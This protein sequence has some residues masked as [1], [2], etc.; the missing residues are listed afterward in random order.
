M[1]L[2]FRKAV[3][4]TREKVSSVSVNPIENMLSTHSLMIGEFGMFKAFWYSSLYVVIEG[5]VDLKLSIPA[6]DVLLTE[7]DH[8]DKLR[9][10]RNGTFHYQKETYNKKILEVDQSDEFVSWIYKLHLVFGEE[11]VTRG[12]AEFST[13]SQDRIRK[14]ITSILG[15]DDYNK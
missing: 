3:K 10:F 9:L 15:D 14:N 11:I 2:L 12:M 1:K 7:K 4:E 13:E 5:Y 8:L 6:I